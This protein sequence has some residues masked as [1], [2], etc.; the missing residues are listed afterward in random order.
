MESDFLV[1]YSITIITAMILIGIATWLT[2]PY[3]C[4][5]CG[6]VMEE[7]YNNVL[8]VTYKVC[9]RCGCKMP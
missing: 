1:V 5:Y 7:E 9:T 8:D 2:K 3:R 6:G 4:P